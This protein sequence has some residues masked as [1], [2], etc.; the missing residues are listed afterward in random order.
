MAHAEDI[1]HRDMKP[2]NVLL[3]ADGT[4]KVA[5]FGIAR[6]AGAG[7]DLTMPGSVVGT[8]TY[9][10]PEQAQ[11]VEVDQRSDVYSLGMVMYE[12]LTGEAPFRGDNPLA[13]AYKQRHEVPPPPSAIN[14]AVPA[15]LDGIVGRAM[16]L[17]PN[18]RQRSAG[19]FRAELLAV[20]QEPAVGSEPTVAFA[21]PAETQI[22]SG[23][24]AGPALAGAG[25]GAAAAAGIAGAAGAG[26]AGAAATG[27]AASRTEAADREAA[28]REAAGLGHRSRQHRR[29]TAGGAT[30]SS[31]WWRCSSWRPSCSSPSSKAVAGA[32]P[33]PRRCRRSSG[34]P[35]PMP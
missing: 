21:P 28:D 29:S 10:S 16:S 13:I 27:V 32:V 6:A 1:V 4:A 22:F 19:E 14:P 20:G 11:G 7:S 12:M 33:P 5:D 15:Q 24:A 2:A 30:S 35:C 25:H 3:A 17:D 31:Q 8:A 9:L 23:P 34:N 18:Q 26:A